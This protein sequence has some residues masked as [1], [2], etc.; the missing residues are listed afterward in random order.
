MGLLDNILHDGPPEERC[1]CC[2][3]DIENRSGCHHGNSR[4]RL[5]AC[6]TCPVKDPSL[7]SPE[8]P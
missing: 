2:Q 5:P 7:L 4:L 3:C 8:T 6:D 1:T